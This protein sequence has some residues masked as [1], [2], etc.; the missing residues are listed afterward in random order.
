MMLKYFKN[1]SDVAAIFFL[2][3]MRNQTLKPKGRRYSSIDKIFA[4]SVYKQSGRA[5]KFISKIFS[6]PSRKVLRDMLNNSFNTGINQSIFSHLKDRVS[7]LKSTDRY[8]VL[9]FDET[10]L[11]AG[12]QYN[13]KTDSVDGFVDFGGKNRPCIC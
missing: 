10:A 6:L 8:C 12:L 2:S 13:T 11:C 4:L 5:Y 1:F 9:M 7:K 3:Q